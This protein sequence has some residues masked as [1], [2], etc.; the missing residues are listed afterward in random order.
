MPAATT[1]AASPALFASFAA[2]IMLTIVPLPEWAVALR[3][4]W[5]ALTLV[6]WILTMPRAIGIGV[7]W[8]LGLF[9]DAARSGL[10]GEHALGLAIVAYIT[11]R[12]HHRLRLFPLYQQAISVGLMLLPYKS[13]SLWINGIHGYGQESW[14]YWTPVLTSLLL[15]PFVFVLLQAAAGRAAIR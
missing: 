11:L 1:N 3:P 12:L 14:L 2:A 13:A 4:E 6:Y 9:V 7:A 8:L 15:W 10:M 5:V